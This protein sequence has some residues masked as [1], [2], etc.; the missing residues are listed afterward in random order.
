MVAT[1][2]KAVISV[3][4]RVR[5]AL[6]VAISGSSARYGATTAVNAHQKIVFAVTR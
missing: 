5:S 1:I 6:L 2:E 4:M 3:E